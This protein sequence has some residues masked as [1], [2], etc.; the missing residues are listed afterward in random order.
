MASSSSLWDKGEPHSLALCLCLT[1]P[2]A[3]TILWTLGDTLNR[4]YRG[5]R[6]WGPALPEPG[7]DCVEG[8]RATT[9]PMQTASPLVVMTT[10]SWLTSMPSSYRRTPGSMIFAP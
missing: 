3:V 4:S 9:L 10:T 2:F 8:T 6:A 1:W 7:Y 5:A